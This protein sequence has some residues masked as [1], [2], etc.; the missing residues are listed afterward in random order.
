MTSSGQY[1]GVSELTEQMKTELI[2]KELTT[3]VFAFAGAQ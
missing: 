2:P 1:L 3:R